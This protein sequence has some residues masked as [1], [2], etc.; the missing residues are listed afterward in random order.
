MIEQIGIVFFGATA[1][2]LTQ[3]RSEIWRRRACLFGICGQPFWVAAT[4]HAHQ[5]GILGIT[6]LYTFSWSKGVWQWWL[7]PRFVHINSRETIVTKQINEALALLGTRQRDKVSG[8]DG[9][10]ISI[11]FDLSGCIQAALSPPVDKDGK[12]SQST[13]FDLGRLAVSGEPALDPFPF[14]VERE[15]VAGPADK[16]AK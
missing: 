10:V 7:R 16:P 8:L 15:A 12:L 4:V 9:V 1:V 14:A 6:A 11:S 13:W 3:S 2:L 5:W